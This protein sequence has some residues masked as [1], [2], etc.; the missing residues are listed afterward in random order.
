MAEESSNQNLQHGPEI[1]DWV[2]ATIA[3]RFAVAEI[4]EEHCKTGHP[5]IVWR[6]GK[7]Y[8]QPPAE[9]KRELEEALKNESWTAEM[10]QALRQL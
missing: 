10:L 9:A 6:D 3:M 1:P 7:V 2:K 4:I 8:R 5:L